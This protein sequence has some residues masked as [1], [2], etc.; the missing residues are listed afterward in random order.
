MCGTMAW[1]QDQVCGDDEQFDLAAWF[2]S[3]SN[4]HYSSSLLRIA[5]AG[6]GNFACLIPQ[7]RVAQQTVKSVV[8]VLSVKSVV[9][10]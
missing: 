4:L 6:V 9:S 3:L 2:P 5:L 7:E 8:S 1:L 10:V